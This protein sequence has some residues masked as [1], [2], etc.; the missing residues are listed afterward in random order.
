M[1]RIKVL[2][3]AKL[4]FMSRN[5]YF[6]KEP[7]VAIR[8]VSPYNNYDLVR[9]ASYLDD[10]LIECDDITKSTKNVKNQY[11]YFTYEMANQVLDFVEKYKG[12]IKTLI[13]ACEAGISRSAGAAAALGKI[14]LG[15]DQFILNS[16]L[17]IPNPHIYTTILKNW[18]IRQASLDMVCRK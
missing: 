13:V 12:S 10:L 17:Y 18:Q 16:P 7:F 9:T 3:K 2:N 4:L 1:F 6:Y 5:K 8:F 14:Y 11:V 15:D